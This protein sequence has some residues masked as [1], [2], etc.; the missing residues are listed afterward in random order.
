M[1]PGADPS[2]SPPTLE[3]SNRSR[4]SWIGRHKKKLIFLAVLIAVSIPIYQYRD[5]LK[6][7]ALW[8]Y[9]GHRAATFQMPAGINLV[10][11]DP[12]EVQLLLGSNP[13]YVRSKIAPSRLAYSP[14]TYRQL[15][16]YDPRCELNLIEKEEI[17]FFGKLTRP[18][19]VKR[20][21]ILKGA[22]LGFADLNAVVLPIPRLLEPLPT[23]TTFQLSMGVWHMSDGPDPVELRAAATDPNDPSHL[24]IQCVLGRPSSESPHHV[25]KAEIVAAGTMDAFL[26]N[27]DS[28]L[29]K[30]PQLP[31]RA[32]TWMQPRIEGNV[33]KLQQQAMSSN[34][35]RLS[36]FTITRTTLP[37]AP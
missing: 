37:A 8:L 14:I 30:M 10:V 6:H 18:D 25:T 19:G 15:A 13:D 29:I 3:Y 34:K 32:G 24:I 36:G 5:S 23:A 1:S 11:D 9:W 35:F 26:Q 2:T 21:V 28:L 27:D 20:I 22:M 33:Q 12:A 4:L 31:T 17:V 7:R 16:K